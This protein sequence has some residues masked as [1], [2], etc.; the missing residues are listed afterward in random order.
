V[1]LGCIEGNHLTNGQLK[2]MCRIDNYD[3][4]YGDIQKAAALVNR[5]VVI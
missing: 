2:T 5:E 4:L 3:A 1:E